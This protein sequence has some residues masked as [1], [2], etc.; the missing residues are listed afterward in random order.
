MDRLKLYVG[1]HTVL[2][3]LTPSLGGMAMFLDSRD[4][5][6]ISIIRNGYWENWI[7]MIFMSVIKP[8]MTVVD[9]GG[10]HGFFSVL[11]GS[12]VGPAGAVYTFEPN[13]FHHKNFLKTMAINALASRV[14]LHRMALSNERGE[15]KLVTL[16]EGGSSI[17][18]EGLHAIS[19]PTEITVPM[20]VLTDYIPFLKA[21]VIKIDIDGGEPLIMDS[22]FQLIDA[23]QSM[24]IFLEYLPIVWNV[25]DPLPILQQFAQR[26]FSFF[27]LQRDHQ[28]VPKNIY[29]LAQH[30]DQLQLDLMLVR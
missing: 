22:L 28:V 6:N 17:Y 21:D 25:P 11:A 10:H 7:A 13:P 4:P 19:Q 3:E 14:H 15:M 16:G 29:E 27:D 18:F 2:T 24:F 12:L 5:V 30:R 26:G 20:G 9:I 23:N 8:G 1:D